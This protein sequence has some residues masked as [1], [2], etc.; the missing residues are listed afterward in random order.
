MTITE[1]QLTTSSTEAT[2]ST[3]DAPADVKP[4]R[5]RRSAIWGA[6]AIAMLL[7][8][9]LAGVFIYNQASDAT[10]VF[11][12]SSDIVRGQTVAK[13]DITTISITSGQDTNTFTATEADEVIGTIAAVDIPQGGLIT[14]SSVASALT[15][16]EGKALVGIIL[17]PGRLPAQQL[18]AG[19]NVVLV[20]VP[21]QGAVPLDVD[22]TADQTIPA[23]V[24]QVH[25]IP[26]TNDVVVDVYVS[27]QAAP[28][29]TSKGAA[30]V[31]A[32]F[33]APGEK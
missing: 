10:Q 24:S 2:S 9:A 21:A 7:L 13:E 19:D 4:V 6:A 14:T 15:V 29:V 31:L 11:V 18:T 5:T 28:T 30:G 27:N 12:A 17:Q 32:L 25:A 20:P 3:K 1:A 16:P 33:L 26:N 23:V 22:I 8:G